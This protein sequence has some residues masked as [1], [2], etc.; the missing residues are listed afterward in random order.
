MRRQG[1]GFVEEINLLLCRDSEAVKRIRKSGFSDSSKTSIV[2]EDENSN[3]DK[4]TYT[5]GELDRR[6]LAAAY[7]RKGLFF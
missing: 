1:G 4:T 7:Y 6:H 3:A 5:P 2:V